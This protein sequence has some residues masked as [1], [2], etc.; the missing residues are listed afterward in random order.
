MALFPWKATGAELLPFASDSESSVLANGEW[1]KYSVSNSG[2]HKISFSDLR[3]DG[4]LSGSVP[5]NLIRL[6]GNATGDLSFANNDDQPKGL[7]QIPL[8]VEDGGDGSFDNGDVVYFFANAA[9]R[10]EFTLLFRCIVK[11][12]RYMT[13]IAIILFLLK[14]VRTSKR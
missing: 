10:P 7:I 12:K 6:Y 9:D 5:S 8:I 13:C 11:R 14:E 3:N 1:F 4:V 2:L